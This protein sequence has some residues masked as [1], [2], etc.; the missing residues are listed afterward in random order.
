LYFAAPVAAFNA[1][2]YTQSEDD[3]RENWSVKVDPPEV[4]LAWLTE[5]HPELVDGWWSQ[6]GDVRYL[7]LTCPVVYK[8]VL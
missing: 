7:G 5:K 2:Q 1:V 4:K 8:A 3:F 6:N